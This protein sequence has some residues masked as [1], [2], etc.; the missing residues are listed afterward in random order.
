MLEFSTRTTAEVF[1]ATRE[2]DP[3]RDPALFLQLAEAVA[4]GDR[5]TTL[6]RLIAEGFGPREFGLDSALPDES[7]QI[8]RGAATQ[9]A[10]RFG[11]TYEQLY[12]DHRRSLDALLSA[13]H[14]LPPELRAPAEFALARRFEAEIARAVDNAATESFDAAQAIASEAR[15]RGFQLA[16]PRAAAIM[17]R[18]LLAAVER[19]VDD[20]EQSRVA[21]ALQ[22][23]GMTRQLGLAV[24][25]ERAQELV[26]DAIERSQGSSPLRPLGAALGIAV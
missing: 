22:L 15:I 19:A 11:A 10:E 26:L 13:G 14:P 12:A 6:L 17:G 5:V 21:A 7:E 16:T 2:A 8:V 18:T 23:V 20:P 24:D 3:G 1:G 25:V 4:S 9:L